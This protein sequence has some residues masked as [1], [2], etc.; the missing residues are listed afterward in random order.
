MLT[1][2]LA[3][4]ALLTAVLSATLGMAGGLVLMGV[5]TAILPVAT[6]M[7]LHGVT[8]LVSN[9]SRA[10]IQREHIAWGPV[11]WYL[12]GVGLGLL[13][14][15]VLVF[16]PTQTMVYLGLGLVPFAARAL[17][18]RHLDFDRPGA[19]VL[20]GALVT[21]V[22]LVCGVAGPILDVFFVRTARRKEGIVA[23]KALTQIVAHAVKIAWFARG[24]GSA[25]PAQIAV[26][27]VAAVL[28]SRLG[29]IL[30]ARIPDADFKRWT[31]RVVLVIG[32]G[33]LLAGALRVA[34]G[35]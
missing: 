26:V 33:Y 31:G 11:R 21:L 16:R 12:V 35:A 22:Q 7:A 34:R 20:C 18:A 9:A 13:A 3:L 10:F 1:A 32:A 6:A 4:A 25:E 19:A 14:A 29:S 27:V 30:L 24:L 8:Q 23:T 17:P 28:G 5:Y 15:S 2:A